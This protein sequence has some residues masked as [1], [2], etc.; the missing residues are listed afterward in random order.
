VVQEEFSFYQVGA[1]IV[2]TL[3]Q[4]KNPSDDWLPALAWTNVCEVGNGDR[5]RSVLCVVCS[6]L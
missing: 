3:L 2:D 1:G 4:K 6:V 5:D